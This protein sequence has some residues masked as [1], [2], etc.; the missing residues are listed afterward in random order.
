MMYL[1]ASTKSISAALFVRREEGQVPIY[2]IS[3]VLQG[4]ELNY[5][6]TRKTNT[7]VGTRSEK[8]TM[9]FSST[10]GSSPNQLSYQKALTKPKNSRRVTKWE[11]ELGEHNIMFRARGASNKETPKDFSIE[12]PPKDNSK[13][14]GRKTDT[15]LKETKLSCEWK[16]YTDG[17]SSSDGLGT[18]LMLI[19]PEGNLRSQATSHQRISTKNKGNPKKRKNEGSDKRKESKEVASIEGAYYQNQGPHMIREVHEGELYKTIDTSDYS[20]IQ[21]EKGTNLRPGGKEYTYALRFEF[22]TMNNEAEYEAFLACL[23]IAQEIKIVNLANFADSQ[24]LVPQQKEQSFH[25]QGRRFCF[26]IA[27]QHRNPADVAGSSYD[28]RS[29]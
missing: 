13:E 28:K 2:F 15:K 19:G 21:T 5:P 17:A 3:K 6:H 11:I 9:I 8:A 20:L 26:T 4:A 12:A 1:E 25:P 10:Y 27:K 22:E 7:S 24:L 29:S 14:V 18:G 23:R 16:V